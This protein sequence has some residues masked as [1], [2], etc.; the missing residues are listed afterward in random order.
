MESKLNHLLANLV[1]EYHKLQNLH[2]YVEGPDFFQA[3]A[4]LEE[5]YDGINGAIDDVAEAI[6]QLG[7]K[8]V[9]SLREVLELASVEERENGYVRSAEAL[10]IVRADFEA[11]LAEVVSVKQYADEQGAHLVSALMDGYIAEFSK[12]VWMISQSQR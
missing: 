7:G 3:H 11:L 10:E 2:W 5:Y 6:L 4:K 12:A 1:V 8:P 9:A